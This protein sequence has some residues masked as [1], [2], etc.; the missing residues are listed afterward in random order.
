VSARLLGALTAAVLLSGCTGVAP[1]PDPAPPTTEPPAPPAA[2]L[3]D[4]EALRVATGLAWAADT[5]TAT[6]TRC[7]YDPDGG[8]GTEFV[9]VDVAQPG[10]P[11][12]QVAELCTAG[13]RIPA[14]EG[15][16]CGLAGGGVFAATVRGGELVTLA[17]ASVPA[18]TTADRLTAALGEQ[19][20]RLG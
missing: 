12:D 13:T 10:V 15:L 2:C 19:L 17:A 20:A 9:V 16:V 1:V 8:T 3:L 18:A 5:T 6:D 14:G 11:L 4:T 7:V